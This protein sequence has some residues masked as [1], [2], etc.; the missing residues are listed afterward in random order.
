MD[1]LA[2]Y[3]KER[4][5]H[6]TYLMHALTVLGYLPKFKRGLKLAFSA[7]FLYTFSIQVLL[8]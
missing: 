2:V 8:N 7:H 4:L 3:V 1:G 6:G 5:L